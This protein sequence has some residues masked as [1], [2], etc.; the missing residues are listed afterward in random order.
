V[1]E[2]RRGH[3]L[4]LEIKARIGLASSTS[5]LDIRPGDCYLIASNPPGFQS[6]LSPLAEKRQR[7]AG[8][9][10]PTPQRVSP[11]KSK[12]TQ[13]SVDTA[14]EGFIWDTELVGLG[15]K[16]TNKGKKVFILQKRVD[17]RLK[18]WTIGAY[19]SVSLKEARTQ[20]KTILGQI[21]LGL[22]SSP[23]SGQL[24]GSFRDE[25][26]KFYQEHV[27]IKLRPTT[28]VEYRSLID[29]HILPYFGRMSLAEVCPKAIRSFHSQLG[30]KLPY[31]ANRAL[32][33]LSKFF[34]WAVPQTSLTANPCR[35]I[36]KFREKRRELNELNLAP[37]LDPKVHPALRLL[38][39]TGMRRGEVL[40][41]RWEYIDWSGS[42][43]RLPDSKT[44][45]KTVYLSPAALGLLRGLP[46]PHEG[47]VWVG[48]TPEGRKGN[49]FLQKVWRKTLREHNLPPLRIHDLRHHYATEACR[50][51]SPTLVAGL[52]GHKDIKTTMRYVHNDDLGNAAAL[53][54][55]QLSKLF[56]S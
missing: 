55:Q 11:M 41:L 12:L 48:N 45:Q 25:I 40:S 54:D 38:M 10:P 29:K 3:Q 23:V 14:R 34:T 6:S 19:P 37:L 43:I 36:T 50:H 52:L 9:R 20:A 24:C 51:L 1:F 53:V 35:G 13:R 26:E 56:K 27:K 47:W 21:T 16:V 30:S 44:G 49:T 4:A 33:L 32:A 18:R 15:L 8:V 7:P 42:C 46:Q 5:T 17:G 22:P 28:Q 39:L 2:S 31:R